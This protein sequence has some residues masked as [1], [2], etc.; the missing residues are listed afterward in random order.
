MSLARVLSTVFFLFVTVASSPLSRA[1]GKNPHGNVW[2]QERA[3]AWQA[4][5]GWMCGADFVPSTAINQLEMWQEETY[6]TT[7]INRELGWAEKIGMGAMR[8]FLHHLA[9]ESDREGFKGRIEKFLEIA[10]RHHIKIMFVF[11]DDCWNPDPHTGRQPRPVTGRHNSGWVQDPGPLLAKDPGLWPVLEEYVKDVMSTFGADDRVLIWDLY[12]EP[13]KPDDASLPLLRKVFQWARE[14]NARQPVTSGIHDWALVD[15]NKVQLGQSDI[16]SYH[17]YGDSAEHRSRIDSLK[18]FNRPMICSEYMA[19]KFN[20]TFQ[21]ILPMLKREKIIAINWG[22]VT[23]K[24][25]T[26]YAWGDT[27]HSDGSEPALWFHDVFRRDG[28][29]YKQ[30]EVDVIRE[31]TLDKNP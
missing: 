22:L 24:T 16:I 13:N 29:P 26:M 4:K 28:R 12:N 19:R 1:Q 7:T 6:D 27:T 5:N 31:M 3:W 18:K 21:T 10:S 23:G 25:N 15:Y 30:E 11:F 8:V 9:W 2:S 14:T 17:S 20:S